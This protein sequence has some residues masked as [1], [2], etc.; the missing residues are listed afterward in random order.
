MNIVKKITILATFASFGLLALMPLS[1]SANVV[2]FNDISGNPGSSFTSGGF[3]FTGT[4]TYA[5]AP[6]GGGANNGTENLIVGYHGGFTIT[7]V[8]GGEF[9]LNQLDAG[10]SWYTSDPSW[11][12]SVGGDLIT[13][14]HSYQT[15]TF[16]NL[17]NVT[18]VTVSS[19]PND[20]YL[21][22]D[23]IV[24]DA[25]VPEPATLLLFGLGM[26]GLATARKK[27]QS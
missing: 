9:T 22:F 4:N 6:G 7:K 21:A 15:F 13:L 27:K 19:A 8:G 12:V 16:D 3:Q 23:N 1:A 10:L 5:W 17:T 26:A 25:N 14:N 18:S 2:T 11:V 24:T 20:G